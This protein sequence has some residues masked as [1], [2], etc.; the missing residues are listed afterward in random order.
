MESVL[1]RY[2]NLIILVGVLFLQVLGLAVQVKRGG[3]DTENTRLI[4][5]WAVGAI[6][7][8]ERGLVWVENSTGNLWHNYFYLRGVRTEN[9]ELKQQIEQMRLEQVRLTEDAAQAHRLQALLAFKEQFVA[10]TEAAQV[11]G[12]SGSDQSRIIWIDKGQDEGL[13]RDM[14]VITAD[15][16]V[17]K[18]LL[19]YKNPSVSQVLLINDQ[20][21]GVGVILEKSRLQGVLRGT[22][23]GEVTLERVM[24]DEQVAPGETVLTSG[25]D[26]IFPK[27]LPVGTVTKVGAGKDLFLNVKVR[28]AANLSK[29][30]EVLVL[31]EKQQQEAVAE[32]TGHTRAADILAQRL[33][34]V[35]EKPPDAN[36]GS[37]ETKPS[38]TPTAGSKIS[39]PSNHAMGGAA[40]AS[41]GPKPPVSPKP[42]GAQ[43]QTANP[44]A[45]PPATPANTQPPTD[46]DNPN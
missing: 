3:N 11:I 45:R 26:Q 13:K 28:P 8:F 4:R 23:N 41:A 6:T 5:I 42:S 2:R 27:G 9:R 46:Q 32:E 43:P 12:W 29:L 21:S 14:P 31:V 18:V 35:P 20:S 38:S 36:A 22:V 33:P 17:G 30:E 24:S 40:Q 44:S 15:G 7:P 16:I 39:H 10:K 37:G 19:V 25:G 1:A 34:S